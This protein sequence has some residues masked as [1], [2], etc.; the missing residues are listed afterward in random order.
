MWLLRRHAPA[1][2]LLT[3]AAFTAAS[4]A[5]TGEPETTTDVLSPGA[6]ASSAGGAG[7]GGGAGAGGQRGADGAAGQGGAG[8]AAGTAGVAGAGVAGVAAGAGSS[9]K[10]VF[11]ITMENESAAAIYGSAHAPYINTELLPKYGH[12]NG[13]DDPLPDNI[14]SEPHYVWMEAGTNRF[15][16]ATF[17]TDADPSAANSTASTAHLTTQMRAAS[18]A[19][20]W[21]SYQE[22]LDAT[23][24]ACP[25]QS[26]GVYVAKHDPF[27]FF[28]DVAGSP[29]AKDNAFCAA[30]HRPYDSGAFA[31]DLMTGNVAQYNF[32]TPDLCHDM[33]G[34]AKC[35]GGDDIAAGDRWLSTELPR[36]ID[37]ANANDG[38]IF[39]VWDEPVGGSTRIPFLVIGPHVKPGYANDL[40]Y[41]HGSFTKTIERIFG[42]PVLPTVAG[43]T[44]FGDF[45]EAGF[46]P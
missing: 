10:H 13:F 6:A 7:G 9:I 46:Y 3:S 19:V 8:G 42:L 2:L 27:V 24:G 11:V 43:D 37:Y 18:P 33:H 36:I 29:P 17:T 1:L 4:C 22:G 31:A 45:F 23:T 26:A 21:M 35:P 20:S 5:G 44:D 38:V 39:I 16:D 32:I 25:V 15:S 12:A 28:D 30:H 34:N 14:P 40:R 41:T